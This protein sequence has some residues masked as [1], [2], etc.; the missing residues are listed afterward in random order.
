MDGSSVQGLELIAVV[1]LLYWMYR[2]Q[3]RPSEDTKKPEQTE[4]K[5][6]KTPK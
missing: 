4:D 6:T 2:S 5:T 3:Q 1:A